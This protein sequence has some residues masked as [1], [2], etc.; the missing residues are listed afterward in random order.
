MIETPR[1]RVRPMRKGD[2]SALHR[3]LSDPE[4]MRFIEPPFTLERTAAFIKSAGMCCPPLVYAITPRND[5]RLIGHL[6]YH[7]YDEASWEIGW[8][9]RRD[10]W[11][12]GFATE[13]TRAVIQHARSAK[14]AGLVLECAEAPHASRRIAEKCGFVLVNNTD[15][16]AVYRLALTGEGRL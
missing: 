14:I 15:G 9:L 16:L 6:I 8:V 7:P 13:L 3:I 10:C 1:M 11:G 4:V 2:T 12:I 5:D